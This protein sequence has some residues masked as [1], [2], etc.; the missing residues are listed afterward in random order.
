MAP[1]AFPRASS[2]ESRVAAAFELM[3]L[4]SAPEAANAYPLRL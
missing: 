4:G 3:Q 1:M 2:G